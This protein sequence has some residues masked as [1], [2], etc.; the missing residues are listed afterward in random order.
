[1][2]TPLIPA[3]TNALLS[4]VGFGAGMVIPSRF[5]ALRGFPDPAPPI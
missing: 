4:S 1:M 2:K 3:R 5:Y